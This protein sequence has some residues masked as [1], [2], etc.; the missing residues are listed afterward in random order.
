LFAKLLFLNLADC[1]THIGFVL[2]KIKLISGIVKTTCDT[3]CS[4]AVKWQCPYVTLA[5]G[6]RVDSDLRT[7]SNLILDEEK[8]KCSNVR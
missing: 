3:M 8:Q 6:V 1:T 5:K 7:L 4:P 2:N